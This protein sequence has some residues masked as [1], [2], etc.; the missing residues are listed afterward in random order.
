MGNN[1]PHPDMEGV[2]QGIGIIK[3]AWKICAAVV[4]FWL[5]RK[6]VLHDALHGF[7]VVQGTGTATLEANLD[8]QLV[9]IS[10]KPVFRVFFRHP[11]GV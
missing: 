2:F 3:V 11:K 10:H 1:G 4:N 8:Q 7:R 9:G 5:K 6:F